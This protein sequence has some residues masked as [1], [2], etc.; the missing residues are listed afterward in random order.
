MG[1][2]DIIKYVMETPHNTNPKL[3]KQK[4]EDNFT[5]DE[6]SNKPFYEEKV[7]RVVVNEFKGNPSIC[8]SY[9]SYPFAMEEVADYV[10]YFD[11]ARYEGQSVGFHLRG[12]NWPFKLEGGGENTYISCTVGKHSISVYK[13][14]EGQE[15]EVYTS[16]DGVLGVWWPFNIEHGGTLVYEPG[17]KYIVGFNDKYYELTGFEDLDENGISIGDIKNGFKISFNSSHVWMTCIVP[18]PITVS[19]H[20]L[21]DGEKVEFFPKIIFNDFLDLTLDMNSNEL[22]EGETYVVNFNGTKYECVAGKIN[23]LFGHEGE[24]ICFGN[25]IIV[26]SQGGA[27][28]DMILS[29]FT[30]NEPFLIGCHVNGDE[31]FIATF[32]Y[33]SYTASVGKVENVVHTIDRKYIKDMYGTEPETITLI[34]DLYLEKQSGSVH[35]WESTSK[36]I[37]NPNTDKVVLIVDGITYTPEPGFNDEDGFIIGVFGLMM[38]TNILAH[39]IVFWVNQVCSGMA[40]AR[41]IT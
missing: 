15:V 11:G 10:V 18:G 8:D 12:D 36:H 38:T 22:I 33:A 32:S 4:I 31:P 5:W 23:N 40:A 16:K 21:V 37:Y 26:F 41:L 24:Y 17:R 28:A 25:P 13:V 3:L 39:L 14:V 2:Q 20:E 6:L 7:E 19:F 27:P 1:K 35:Y 9:G 34:E 29:E 30:T